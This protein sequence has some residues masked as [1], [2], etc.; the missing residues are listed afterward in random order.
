MSTAAIASAFPTTQDC[1]EQVRLGAHRA[2]VDLQN[3][4]KNPLQEKQQNPKED[5]SNRTVQ[6]RQKQPGTATSGSCREKHSR[7]ARL[8]RTTQES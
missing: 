6:S 7:T 1:N 5:L 8:R 4:D 3:E 2:L